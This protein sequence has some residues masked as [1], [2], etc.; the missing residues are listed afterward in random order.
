MLEARKVLQK[1]KKKTQ[2]KKKKKKKKTFNIPE[3]TH[4]SD[5]LSQQNETIIANM[6]MPRVSYCHSNS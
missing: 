2:K 3:W 5:R 1:K 4:K 6:K